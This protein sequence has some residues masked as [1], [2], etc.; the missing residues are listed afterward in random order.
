MLAPPFHLISLSLARHDLARS[1]LLRSSTFSSNHGNERCARLLRPSD[2]TDV[3]LAGTTTEYTIWANPGK[4]QSRILSNIITG[5]AK[6][7]KTEPFT[8]RPHSFARVDFELTS[9]QPHVTLWRGEISKDIDT[10]EVIDGVAAAIKT[11]KSSTKTNKE[12]KVELAG[13]GESNGSLIAMMAPDA[14]FE[15]LHAVLTK[16]LG[17]FNP[18]VHDYKPHIALLHESYAES[19]E[20]HLGRLARSG[21]LEQPEQDLLQNMEIE[22]SQQLLVAQ[23]VEGGKREYGVL[24]ELDV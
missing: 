15:E 24:R 5:L 7:A 8:V 18:I 11:F 6:K 19:D 21:R 1:A 10:D 3:S 4:K 14:A 9:A 12:L 2:T 13:I 22:L 17:T 20:D 16:S 23:A